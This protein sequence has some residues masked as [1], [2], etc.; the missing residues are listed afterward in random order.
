MDQSSSGGF[1]PRRAVVLGGIG[2]G[3][4]SSFKRRSKRTSPLGDAEIMAHV[5]TPRDE[6]TRPRSTSSSARGSY[7]DSSSSRAPSTGGSRFSS[8]P[9]SVSPSRSFR[10]S[11]GGFGSRGT[12]TS[13]SRGGS[14]FSSRGSSSFSS[15]G[16][17][18]KRGRGGETIHA[19]RFV[20][21]AVSVEEE[22]VYTPKHQFNDFALDERLKEN[23]AKKGYV[24]PTAIQDQAVPHALLGR[25]VIGIANTGEGKTA[26]FLLPI[27]HKLI[28][29]PNERA[30]IITPTR[31]LALQIEQEFFGFG[32]GLGLRSVLAI[33]GVGLGPQIDRLRRSHVHIIIGTPGRLKDLVERKVLDLSKTHL[34]VLDEADRMLDMGF[35]H[36]IKYLLEL[37]PRDRQNLFFSA[38]FAGE[39]ERLAATMLRDPIKIS[40]KKTETSEHIDQDVITVRSK[41]EKFEKLVELLGKP[42]FTKVLVFGRTKWGVEKLGRALKQTGLSAVAIH[43]DKTQG[44]RQKSLQDFKEGKA[45]IMVATDVAARGLDIP[46]VSHVINFDAPASYDDYVHRIGRTGRAGKRGVALT[47]ID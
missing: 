42:E 18:K 40:V 33:G 32:R 35:I 3:K 23:I 43:G 9:R 12:T 25:D 31:E 26:A 4:V 11:G 20:N 19:S 15:R 34:V 30:I 8:V 28:N 17:S 38:T 6:S 10:P 1:R 13:S 21:K 47:F 39:V 24:I 45:D 2:G 7:R 5:L 29:H 44:Q 37:L 27:L 22:I 14:S 36:D 41:E 16:S 46:S